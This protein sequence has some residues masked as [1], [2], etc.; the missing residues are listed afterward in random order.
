MLGVS[1]LKTFK[2]NSIEERYPWIPHL[3]LMMS[4]VYWILHP[5]TKK[6]NSP[7][8][9]AKVSWAWKCRWDSFKG[10]TLDHLGSIHG[11]PVRVVTTRMTWNILRDFWA[12]VTNLHLSRANILSEKGRSKVFVNDWVD[13]LARSNTSFPPPQKSSLIQSTAFIQQIIPKR[14]QSILQRTDRHPSAS[15]FPC[16]KN[17]TPL[18]MHFSTC[19]SSTIPWP[20]FLLP[21]DLITSSVAPQVLNLQCSKDVPLENPS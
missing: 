11:A 17:P 6:T 12:F 8:P 16:W 13:F 5:P 3:A 1:W 9:S 2:A 18:P 4:F 19:L 7:K 10:Y 21:M 15:M 14:K 20:N